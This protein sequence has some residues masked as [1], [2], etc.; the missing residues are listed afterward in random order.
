MASEEIDLG[1]GHRLRFVSWG[2]DRMLN[3]QYLCMPDVDRYGAIIRHE[4]LPSDQNTTCVRD[5]K[6][7]G[8]ILFAGE[9]Q[10]ESEPVTTA[11]RVLSWEP[12]TLDPSL[13]CHCGDHG[14][15]R[16]GRWVPA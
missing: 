1:Y 14:H 7:Q 6:C 8:Y 3:P 4:L 10:Q 2:P 15:I 11:W 13:Q 5:G 9:V 12:L 16:E